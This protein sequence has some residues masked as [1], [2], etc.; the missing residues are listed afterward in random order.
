[1]GRCRSGR[2]VLPG[3]R[4]HY[5]RSEDLIRFLTTDV[6]GFA[7]A[8]PLDVAFANYNFAAYEPLPSHN[9][10]RLTAVAVSQPLPF[11]SRCRFTAVAV[12]QSLPSHSHFRFTAVAVSQP[13]PPHKQSRVS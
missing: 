11:H 12:S 6:A 5:P 9:H 2:G 13:L 3:W 7:A 8:R 1:M 10:F 4:C